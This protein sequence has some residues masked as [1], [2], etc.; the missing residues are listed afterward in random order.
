MVDRP[1]QIANLARA[2]GEQKHLNARFLKPNMQPTDTILVQQKLAYEVGQTRIKLD[3]K[4]KYNNGDSADPLNVS[5]ANIGYDSTGSGTQILTTNTAHYTDS[6]TGFITLGSPFTGDHTIEYLV[7]AQN[8]NSDGPDAFAANVIPT[9]GQVDWNGLKIV[10]LASSKYLVV[11]PP[12]R[13]TNELQSGLGKVPPVGISPPFTNTTRVVTGPG[14]DHYYWYMTPGT[15]TG[16]W[17]TSSPAKTTPIV[18]DSRRIDLVQD[19]RYRYQLPEILHDEI[20]SGA[21]GA[22][23]PSGSLFL[24]DTTEKTVIE[25]VT[26]RVPELDDLY[27]AAWTTRP[28][29]VIQIE[30]A[31][32]DNIFSGFTSTDDTDDPADYKSRFGV[33][34]VGN[35]VSA[36]ID[37]IRYH[38]LTQRNTVDCLAKPI[39]HHELT[40]M[41]PIDGDRGYYAFGMP[42]RGHD[43][44]PDYLS[45]QGA[46]STSSLTRDRLNNAMVGNLFLAANNVQSTNISN[47]LATDSLGI[48]FG[49][50]PDGPFFAYRNNWT[51][52]GVADNNSL[53]WPTQ[54]VLRLDNYPLA[55]EIP[56]IWFGT[57][58][59]INF[60]DNQNAF[61]F[62][63]GDGTAAGRVD[64]SIITAGE[65]MIM[66]SSWSINNIPTDNH[67]A[68]YGFGEWLRLFASTTE[69]RIQFKGHDL[70]LFADPGDTSNVRVGD[71]LNASTYLHVYNNVI[72]LSGTD[73]QPLPYGITKLQTDGN[74]FNGDFRFWKNA[75]NHASPTLSETAGTKLS[76]GTLQLQNGLAYLNAGG[77]EAAAGSQQILFHS[78]AGTLNWMDGNFDGSV[79]AT[80]DLILSG[81]GGSL[82]PFTNQIKLLATQATTS[83]LRV[84]QADGG[85][86]NITASG[87]L[88]TEDGNVYFQ[89][90]SEQD[91]IRFNDGILPGTG[92]FH[93][94][95]AGSTL[96]TDIHA[97]EI[98][99]ENAR[100]RNIY[101]PI[102]SNEMWR[103]RLVVPLS[104]G[105]VKWEFSTTPTFSAAE[106]NDPNWPSVIQS[107]TQD[108]TGSQHLYVVYDLTPWFGINAR[109]V[110]ATFGV[111]R[112]WSTSDAREFTIQLQTRGGSPIYVKDAGTKSDSG[113][114]TT[115]HPGDNASGSGYRLEWEFQWPSSGSAGDKATVQTDWQGLNPTPGNDV[116]K[117]YTSS[118]VS[119]TVNI[120]SATDGTTGVF[121]VV[122]MRDGSGSASYMQALR[123]ARFYLKYE[124]LE[125]MLGAFPDVP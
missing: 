115:E 43:D 49:S 103:R 100:I 14:Q 59:G 112:A 73:P 86:A 113:T 88:V 8:L 99:V 20:V 79:F 125:E 58:E 31:D 110:H 105:F 47:D 83:T 10:Q 124:T 36:A 54:S 5:L 52:S 2:I 109:V 93:F 16:H 68:G 119:S 104:S 95:T 11:L 90:T 12:R 77:S 74:A 48:F 76:T 69:S 75:S 96:N 84:E 106:L 27:N 35:S 87:D 50:Y 57:N 89:Q 91:R 98:H 56:T 25:G 102:G 97:H 1:L 26:F 60:T 85:D 9:P 64:R 19:P 108:N 62:F 22:S 44:H 45:R 66:G 39:N 17:D 118:S 94:E 33:I 23:L 13:P 101:P 41:Q 55:L 37:R 117:L 38:Q 21:A 80:G 7:E 107:Y 29:W 3:F 65:L 120:D 111:E 116:G 6:F 82:S 24:W 67:D 122:Q 15:D 18:G 78:G 61:R 123:W 81:E 42:Y 32:L 40:A 121:L 46:H 4:P 114:P 28:G 71:D 53:E 70:A 30:G 34:A 51:R 92:S 72:Y 63:G